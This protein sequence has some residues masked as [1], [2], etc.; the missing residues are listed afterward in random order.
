MIAYFAFGLAYLI[1]S[2]LSIFAPQLQQVLQ[3]KQSG[4]VSQSYQGSGFT[5]PQSLPSALPTQTSLLHVFAHDTFQR[6]DQETWGSA[7]DQQLWQGDD[8]LHFAIRSG[9][10]EIGGG[11]GKV[12]ALL[13]PVTVNSDVLFTG[14][15]SD[16]QQGIA[17]M[18]VVLRYTNANTWDKAYLDGSHLSIVQHVADD[19][20]SLAFIPFEAH[21]GVS[22]CVRFRAEGTHLEAKAWQSNAQ[23]PENWML[24]ANDLWLQSGQSGIRIVLQANTHVRVTQF[25][26]QPVQSPING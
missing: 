19:S 2:L 23:E 3:A 8:A 21:A 10:G 7:S 4:Y 1:V 5:G 24:V 17:N 14:S 11:K 25:L 22:Y 12:T 16:F 18:G 20:L 26:V 15:I 6:N 9:A 13:G